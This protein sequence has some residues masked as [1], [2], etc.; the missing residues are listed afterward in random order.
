MSNKIAKKHKKNNKIIK[1]YIWIC[2]AVV[3]VILLIMATTKTIQANQPVVYPE[4]ISF[5]YNPEIGEVEAE[6]LGENFE[7]KG[8]WQEEESEDLE[9]E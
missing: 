9:N 3:G 1:K 7:W 2:M 8:Y 5:S 6:E 4:A